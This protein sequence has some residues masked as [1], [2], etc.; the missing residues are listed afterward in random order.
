MSRPRKKRSESR[1]DVHGLSNSIHFFVAFKTLP[2]RLLRS[3][4]PPLTPIPPSP[5][6]LVHSAPLDPHLCASAIS[7]LHRPPVSPPRSNTLRP[8]P[9]AIP[10]ELPEPE[11]PPVRSRPPDELVVLRGGHEDNLKTYIAGPSNNFLRVLS[12][13]FL[14]D[15]P[16]LAHM[17]DNLLSL[18]R[19]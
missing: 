10:P 13:A 7:T 6:T 14:A 9:P 5:P 18:D 12:S 11:Y 19:I 15:R 16:S 4:S 1:Q 8:T 3:P 2:L 17:D